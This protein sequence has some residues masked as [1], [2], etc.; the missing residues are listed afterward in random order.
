VVALLRGSWLP[1]VTRKI[2]ER[3]GWE[4]YYYGNVTQSPDGQRWQTFDHRPR[5]NNNYF[6]LRNR[7]AILSEAYS[8]ATFEERVRATYAFVEEVLDY[9]LANRGRIEEAVARADRE[10]LPGRVLPTRADFARS[11]PDQVQ[12]LMGAVAEER[13]PYSGAV[14]LRRLDERR[15][16]P[17]WEYGTFVPTDSA[18]VPA[19]Y[20]VPAQLGGIID[21]LSAHGVRSERLTQARTEMVE[22]FVIDST[23]ATEQP[24]QGHRE[25]TVFGSYRTVS[26]TL[27]AGT[28]VVDVAQP[29]GRLAFYLLEPRSDDGFLNW[30]LLDD[31]L[32]DGYPITRRPAPS[33]P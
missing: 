17:M 27:P 23:R 22:A 13:N 2:R 31:A 19:A 29:L 32:A 15:P 12:I 1:E 18:R 14:M 30:G 6:G 20:Y 11:Y 5:F 8:Y 24:F 3:Y 21:R 16:T 10:A 7:V 33:A 28:V 25:R 26:R 9:A 4:F